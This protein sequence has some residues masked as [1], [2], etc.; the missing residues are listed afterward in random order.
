VD[1]RVLGHRGVGRYLANVLEAL[2]HLKHPHQFL[3]YLGPASKAALVPRDPRFKAVTLAQ[4]HPALV[5]QWALPQAAARAGADLLFYPDNSG[6]IFPTRPMVLV[7]HDTMWKRPLGQ[8]I[9]LPTLRQRVQDAYRKLVCPRAVA[10]AE[11]VITISAH[12]A[13]CLDRALGLRP[14]KLTV[15]AEAADA[16]L[17]KRLAMAP[18]ARLRKALGV[19][20][21]Y[22]LASGAADKR[23]NVDRLIQAFALAQRQDPRLAK[24]KLV[25]TSLRPGEEATTDYARTAQ[26]AGVEK[27]LSFVGYV[28][29]SQMK[30]LYQGALC[31]A[32]PSLWEG[33]GLPVLEAF[34]LG[35]PVLLSREG[36]LPEVG[37]EAAVYADPYS[38]EDLARGLAQASFGRQRNALIKKGLARERLYTWEACAKAHLKVFER[39]AGAVA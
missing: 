31:L 24:A 18:A 17:R 15:I 3:V 6:A 20:G 5:E 35:C 14:P 9:A 7:Q 19:T 28:D 27:A 29:D 39:A 25:I 8:A 33:F 21:P 2:S 30:A 16:G 10:A 12:S 1:G 37:A 34:A 11:A 38:V 4:R 36:S 13:A 32:F 26:A 22:V 23:K